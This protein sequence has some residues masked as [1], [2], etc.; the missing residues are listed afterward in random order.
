MDRVPD[1]GKSGTGRKYG[2]VRKVNLGDPVINIFK[3][4]EMET[5]Y[6]FWENAVHI[7]GSQEIFVSMTTGP[8]G[9][10]INLGD[11]GCR[12]VNP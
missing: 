12:S 4:R 3:F 11:P 5:F 10:S 7:L 8:R 2:E 6:L 9:C 1:S